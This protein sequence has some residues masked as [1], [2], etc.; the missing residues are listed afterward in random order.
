MIERTAQSDSTSLSPV[1]LDRDHALSLG[2][3]SGERTDGEVNRLLVVARGA[4]ISD[5]D[6]DRLA[7]VVGTVDLDLLAAMS[8][9]CVH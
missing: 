8:A 4:F 3:D 5:S 9:V 7:H 1:P 2:G 6:E